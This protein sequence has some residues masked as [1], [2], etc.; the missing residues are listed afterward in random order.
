M[1]G[2]EP[3][4]HLR[5][6]K[7]KNKQ[8]I[9]VTVAQYL[10]VKWRLVWLR[11]EF[12]CSTIVTEV[13]ELTDKRAVFRATAT[14]VDSDGKLRGSASGTGSET[15]GDWTDFIEKA[16]TK[17]IGRAVAALGYGTQFTEDLDDGDR[18]V[19]A[20]LEHRGP[21]I[22]GADPRKADQPRPATA[23]EI[24]GKRE[25]HPAIPQAVADLKA[26]MKDKNW[27]WAG[28]VETVQPIW[29][30]LDFND[31]Q[32]IGVLRLAEMKDLVEDKKHVGAN[33]SGLPALLPG[34][35]PPA[36]DAASLDDLDFDPAPGALAI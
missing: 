16:E 10:D 28:L 5:A 29:P 31:P 12:P 1:S 14:R 17:A 19:D 26:A 32:A 22:G 18:I 4:K 21:V 13:I 24:S 33:A 30:G 6:L 25:P 2:F 8:G 3:D 27:T 9:E 36:D 7:R 34:P 15:V 20:P 23:A 11:T 35:K